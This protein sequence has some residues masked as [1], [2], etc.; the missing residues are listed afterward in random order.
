LLRGGATGSTLWRPRSAPT[1]YT[2][3]VTSP[4]SVSAFAEAVPACGRVGQQLP[5]GKGF[6]VGRESD[7]EQWRWMY[8]TN[9]IGMMR[10]TRALLR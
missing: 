9:V 7:D 10:V 3:D 2:L 8:E 4:E 5:V 6:D 1:A